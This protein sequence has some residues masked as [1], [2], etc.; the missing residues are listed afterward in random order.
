MRNENHP[1]YLADSFKRRRK[2]KDLYFYVGGGGV[3]DLVVVVVAF[4]PRK[5]GFWGKVRGI[6]P[7]KSF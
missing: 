3:E 2:V 1:K 6:I 7:G 4:S 5:R